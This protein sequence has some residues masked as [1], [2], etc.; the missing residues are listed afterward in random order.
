MGL[1]I[2]L[3]VPLGITAHAFHAFERQDEFGVSLIARPETQTRGSFARTKFARNT[4]QHRVVFGTVSYDVG[5]SGRP[6]GI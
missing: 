2:E 3:R 6:S 1:R 4:L 5:S